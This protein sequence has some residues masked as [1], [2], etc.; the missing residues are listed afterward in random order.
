MSKRY[1][2]Q[3][4]N[5]RCLCDLYYPAFLRKKTNSIDII[6]PT[7]DMRELMEII[8]LT[9]CQGKANGNHFTKLNQISQFQC[10]KFIETK[11]L[12]ELYIKDSTAEDLK[13]SMECLNKISSKDE[14]NGIDVKDVPM[15]IHQ[16]STKITSS[17]GRASFLRWLSR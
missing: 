2:S 8:P 9:L 10:Q 16:N 14:L 13:T 11:S 1:Y 15:E 3:T 4:V 12:K 5:I 7:L 17:M 6:L